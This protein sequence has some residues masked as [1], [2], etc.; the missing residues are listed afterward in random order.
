MKRT[1]MSKNTQSKQCEGISRNGE[2]C[3][4]KVKIQKDKNENRVLCWKHVENTLVYKIKN[5]EKNKNIKKEESVNVTDN[6]P[7]DCPICLDNVKTSDNADFACGH[8]I[9]IDCAKQ[10]HN[11]QCPVCR[12]EISTKKLS[13]KEINT[14]KEK[15]K[16]DKNTE[17]TRLLREL[18]ANDHGR[19]NFGPADG[20]FVD[21]IQSI[22]NMVMG[23]VV[24]FSQLE[25][26]LRRAEQNI[27]HFSEIIKTYKNL[28]NDESLRVFQPLDFIVEMFSTINSVAE[29]YETRIPIPL[30]HDILSEDI[31]PLYPD[32]DDEDL[33]QLIHLALGMEV[34]EHYH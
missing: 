27:P 33:H 9:H 4:K 18:L 22:L 3:N 15:Y 30:I 11:N 29:I 14:I 21:G 31:P 23:D 19:G 2:R 17:N 7:S 28:L 8:A 16:N 1:K 12:A 26:N 20:D 34:T 32:M 13:K 25:L 10:L 6:L 5:D 24:R